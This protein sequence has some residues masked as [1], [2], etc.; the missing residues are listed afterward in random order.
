VL[1]AA[2]ALRAVSGLAGWTLSLGWALLL[3]K[4]LRVDRLLAV[5]SR[6][7]VEVNGPG[8]GRKRRRQSTPAF[9]VLWVVLSRLLDGREAK[10]PQTSPRHPGGQGPRFLDGLERRFFPDTQVT[11]CRLAT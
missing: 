10:C 5:E 1:S 11:A 7:A 2:Y 8:G 9:R 3:P 4:A 6:L